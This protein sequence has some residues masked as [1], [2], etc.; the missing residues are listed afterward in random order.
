MAAFYRRGVCLALRAN[1]EEFQAVPHDIVANGFLYAILSHVD[2]HLF[3][4]F[5]I[6]HTPAL[7]AANVIVL[8]RVAVETVLP[9]TGLKTPD[10][11]MGREKVKVAVYG[12]QADAWEAL[13]HDF[14]DLVRR[15]MGA[16][17]PDFLKD[18]LA[19]FGHARLFLGVHIASYYQT[20][21]IPII[22][23]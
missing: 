13:A 22:F 21:I 12:T 23:H 6:T 5:D 15:G 7:G 17:L 2:L 3:D 20:G 9:S 1:A 14:I 19:L 16:Q 10:L 8:V 18:S 11:A 4:A